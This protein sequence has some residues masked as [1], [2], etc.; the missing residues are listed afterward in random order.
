MK[1]DFEYTLNS[2]SESLIGE[3]DP[4]LVKNVVLLGAESSNGYRFA[5]EAM[6]AAIPLYQKKPVFLSHDLEAPHHRSPR[7][8]AGYVENPRYE[9]GKI[10][11]DIR[12]LD[13]EA[14]RTFLETARSGVSGFGMSHV[15]ANRRSKDGKTIEAINRVVSVDLVMSPATTKSFF[16]QAGDPPEPKDPP[17]MNLD[18]L[19]TKHPDLV[20]AIAQ[21]AATRVRSELNS[22]AAKVAQ[23]AAQKKA[24]DEAVMVERNRQ[25]EIR[26]LC[27]A[28]GCA[29]KADTLCAESKSV[30]EVK[31]F[32]FQEMCKKNPAPSADPA[33]DQHG[34]GTDPD[35]RFK[36][37]Y[38]ES[39]A[40][41]INS[42]ITEA[43]YIRT[44]RLDEGL[45]IL[46]PEQKK[47]D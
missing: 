37:E 24:V 35:K 41:Y 27:A 10:R 18:E 8:L 43:E 26:K 25:T 46:K 38:A 9:A 44:R 34:E 28:A 32:L 30:L 3:G 47:A 39:R 21:E 20:K 5:E 12:T 19:K 11:G 17:A 15:A 42:G 40:V 22:E 16:E 13:S 45:D 6:Q 14:G 1:L 29:E 4:R 36:K 23:E 7:D 2:L 33:G 31:D